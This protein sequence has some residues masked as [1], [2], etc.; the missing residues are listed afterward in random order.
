MVYCLCAYII[1]IDVEGGYLWPFV[2]WSTKLHREIIYSQNV[3]QCRRARSC[4][5]TDNNL[6]VAATYEATKWE[7]KKNLVFASLQKI[8]FFTLV[9]N[10][11]K[12]KKMYTH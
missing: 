8:K 4:W 1:I 10:F 9:E 5:L 3:R 11:K 7:R 6:S 12:K 2:S